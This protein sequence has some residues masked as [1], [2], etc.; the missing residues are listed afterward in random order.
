MRGGALPHWWNRADR[1][2]STGR[3]LAILWGASRKERC[4][5]GAGR[6]DQRRRTEKEEQREHTAR[7]DDARETR[8]HVLLEG[9]RRLVEIDDLDDAHIIVGADDTRDD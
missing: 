4:R 7:S 8:A 2:G 3:P 6:G 1:T 9:G 5:G